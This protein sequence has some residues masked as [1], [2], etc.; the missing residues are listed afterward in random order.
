MDKYISW[1]NQQE[2]SDGDGLPNCIETNGMINN[3]GELVYT[4]PYNPDSDGDNLSDGEEMGYIPRFVIDA[5][6]NI[7]S[8]EFHTAIPVTYFSR[9]SGYVY[10]SQTS[11]ADSSDSDGDGANDGEDSS[12][13]L[14]N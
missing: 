14:T 2:D 11:A 3:I 9:W 13:V 6:P 10:Y 4:D 1:L 12:L 5:V 7:E 8:T